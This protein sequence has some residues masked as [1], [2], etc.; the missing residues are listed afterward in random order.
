MRDHKVFNY[1][2]WF[3]GVI[4]KFFTLKSKGLPEE[5]LT[6]PAKSNNDFPSKLTFIHNRKIAPKFEG[7]CLKQDYLSFTHR[8]VVNFV[9]ELDTLSVDLNDDFRLKY[10]CLEAMNLMNILVLDMV[11]RLTHVHSFQFKTLI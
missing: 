5:T 9:Y 7:N 11:L 1:F 8:H 3:T 4:G 10:C 6:D 2:Y